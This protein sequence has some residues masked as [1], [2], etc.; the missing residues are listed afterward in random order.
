M[1][2]CSQTS[3]EPEPGGGLSSGTLAATPVRSPLS[4]FSAYL[5]RSFMSPEQ[6][7]WLP[8]EHG[9]R[10]QFLKFASSRHLTLRAPQ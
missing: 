1:L 2:E 3:W 6:L 9:M 8:R 10:N 5:P 4:D 7:S